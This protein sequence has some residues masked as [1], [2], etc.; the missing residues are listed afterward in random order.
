MEV[1]NGRGN[2]GQVR[3]GCPFA[4]VPTPSTILDELL[5]PATAART[6]RA[7]HTLH[8]VVHSAVLNDP[9]PAGSYETGSV[10]RQARDVRLS[11]VTLS[12]QVHVIRLPKN[13]C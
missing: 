2:L 10:R 13:P 4:L 3:S 7:R 6:A 8:L 11:H 5:H 1:D 12:R 9:G